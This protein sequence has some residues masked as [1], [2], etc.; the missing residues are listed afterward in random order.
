MYHIVKDVATLITT[1]SENGR[2]PNGPHISKQNAQQGK[3]G[4]STCFKSLRDIV[5]VAK[6]YRIY[7]WMFVAGVV[8]KRK[9]LSSVLTLAKKKTNQHRPLH[10]DPQRAG[11]MVNLNGIIVMVVRN[12]MN[13]PK[14][15]LIGYMLSLSNGG[16]G[17]I[18]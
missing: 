2:F 12:C 8:R 10:L 11:F 7:S 3:L 14:Y 16:W 1:S 4:H 13:I 9:G 18:V 5:N 6:I 15:T 17:K